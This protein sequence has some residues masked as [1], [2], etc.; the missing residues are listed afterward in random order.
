LAKS[1]G[2]KTMLGC[3]VSSSISVKSAAHLSPLIDY[4]DLEGNLLIANGPCHGVT[5]QKG[6]LVLP[7]G[8]GLGMRMLS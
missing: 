5:V 6:R 4:R 1:L 8:P 3:T 7:D 2:M